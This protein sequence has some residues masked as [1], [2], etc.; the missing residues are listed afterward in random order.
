MMDNNR[1]EILLEA[2]PYIRRF[3]GKTIVIKFG[4][5]AMASDE[6]ARQFARDIVLLQHVGIKPVIVHGG[7]PQISRLLKELNI[8]SEFVDGHR[9]TD[10]AAMD[11]VEM[12]LAGKINKGIV[13]LINN[14]GG[15]AA[16]ISGKDGSLALAEPHSL[17][18]T[19]DAGHTEE[20]SLGRVGRIRKDGINPEIL[21]ALE[22]NSYVPVIAPVATDEAGNSLNINADTMAGA[23]ASSLKAEKLILLTDTAGVLV[24]DETITGLGP[25][26]VHRLKETGKITGGMIP[27][28]DCCLQA[29]YSGVNRT[30]IIDGR[31]PHAVLL[32]IFTDRGVGTL[33][34][35]DFDK[36]RADAPAAV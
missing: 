14:E 30:H 11:V 8:P 24:D 36:N 5:A 10:Q 20:V 13:A 28:V 3:T 12:V 2:L 16:G 35:N 21:K 25:D 26:D 27:K 17:K 34:S 4:G 33:I 29:L 15:R 22:D 19:N 7:G 1:A 9:V 18:R 31:V 23:V 32:E 6:L